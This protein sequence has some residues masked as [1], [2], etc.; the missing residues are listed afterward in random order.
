MRIRGFGELEAVI[1]DRIWSRDPESPT[2]VREVF[3]E[4]SAERD[5]AYTTV[6]STMDNLHTKGWLARE[7]DGK[8]YRYWPTLS[9]EEHS[10]R[11]MREALDGG[12]RP[13]L[14]LHHFVEQIGVEESARLH[15]A[16]RRLAK[17][18]KR[19]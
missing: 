18:T 11:L 4:L 13:E 17:R 9:R 5:I 8:A 12:G 19:R 6:M 15:D 7:R 2:T 16:L 1:M 10:A 14:V 3:D